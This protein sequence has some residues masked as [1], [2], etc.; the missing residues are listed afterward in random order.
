MKGRQIIEIYH[1]NKC[2]ITLIQG[3]MS[4]VYQMKYTTKES[5]GQLKYTVICAKLIGFLIAERSFEKRCEQ[6]FELRS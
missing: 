6:W 1:V 5:V 3:D 2:I 4:C